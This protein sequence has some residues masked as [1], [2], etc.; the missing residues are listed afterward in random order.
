MRIFY[1][2][3]PRE[4][5]EKLNYRTSIS[6][7]RQAIYFKLC[8]DGLDRETKKTKNSQFGN[9][10]N[11][12]SA[13]TNLRCDICTALNVSCIQNLLR[14][15]RHVNVVDVQRNQHC[16]IQPLLIEAEE[17]LQRINS[18]MARRDLIIL[19]LFAVKAGHCDST[20]LRQS[21]RWTKPAW[22]INPMW[23]NVK[24]EAVI[25]RTKARLKRDN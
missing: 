20:Q 16:L 14:S 7:Q 19:S 1:Q 17:V 11:A 6:I 25:N 10:W 23:E 21:P 9:K 12:C 3:A 24:S 8:Q 15:I 22:I 4:W 2:K 5:E 13:A 18:R